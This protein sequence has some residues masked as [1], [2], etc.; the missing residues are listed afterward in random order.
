MKYHIRLLGFALL[1]LLAGCNSPPLPSYNP[2]GLLTRYNSGSVAGSVTV[3]PNP[4]MANTYVYLT[5]VDNLETAMDKNNVTTPILVAPGMH[6][7]TI[8]LC[9]GFGVFTNEAAGNVTLLAT[10]KPGIAYTLHSTVPT[11]G[12]G[13]SSVTATVW[14]E[15]DKGTSITPQTKFRLDKYGSVLVFVPAAR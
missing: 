7:M 12:M 13:F 15:D 10:I 6:L 14:I 1:S 3:D 4:L 9:P 8:T 2:P 5:A 11:L